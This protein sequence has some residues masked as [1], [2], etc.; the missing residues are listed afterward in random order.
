MKYL[1]RCTQCDWVQEVTR[2][3][4]DHAIV[5]N[6]DDAEEGS[7]E[8]GNNRW[9]RVYEVPAIMKASYPD[10]LKRKGWADLKESAKLEK[11]RAVARTDAQ[12]NEIAQEITKMGIKPGN[13][14][15]L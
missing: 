5:P 12:K 6:C 10:G 3:M 8:C 9:V 15:G 1:W 11:E 14:S 13:S 2:P 7:C 4:A